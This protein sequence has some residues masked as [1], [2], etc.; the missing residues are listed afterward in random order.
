M[1]I[2]DRILRDIGETLVGGLDADQVMKTVTAAA[3]KLTGGASGAFLRVDADDDQLLVVRAGSGRSRESSLGVAIPVDARLLATALKSRSPVR[4]D[5]AAASEELVDTLDEIMP[6]VRAPLRSAIVVAVRSR[7]G[8]VAGA[9]VVAHNEPDRFTST[10]EQ[11]LADICLLYTSPSPRD[12][13]RSRMPS[14]A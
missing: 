11:L 9:L 4:I 7:S 12:R 8:E 10:E 6:S 2:R 1:C 13:T 14:S 5:D 3:R